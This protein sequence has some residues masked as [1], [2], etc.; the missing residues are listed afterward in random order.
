MNW[1]TMHFA[2]ISLSVSSLGSSIVPFAFRLLSWLGHNV[3]IA[4]GILTSMKPL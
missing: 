3:D 2:N 1:F 4:T